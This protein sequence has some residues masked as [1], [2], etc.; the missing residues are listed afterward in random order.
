M[1][2]TPSRFPARATA[3]SGDDDKVVTGV[4][5]VGEKSLQFQSPDLA[6]EM[7][8]EE[9]ELDV[10]HAKNSP[11][12][13]SHPD[14][15]AWQFTA[16]DQRILKETAFTRRPN[17]LRQIKEGRRRDEGIG[18]VV[19]VMFFV[20][21][22]LGIP[23]VLGYQIEQSVPAIAGRVP[24]ELDQ[25]LGQQ[26]A[27]KILEKYPTD[28]KNPKSLEQLNMLLDRI[29][30]AE[31]RKI[32]TF[33]IHLIDD[34]H[35]NSFSVPSGDIFIF[36]GVLQ[37]SET[38]DTV[39]AVLATEIAFIMTRGGIQSL[40]GSKSSGMFMQHLL[41]NRAAIAAMLRSSSDDLIS[42][43][44]PNSI[45]S[46]VDQKAIQLLVEAKISPF[47]T[48]T[49]FR[50]LTGIESRLE[51]EELTLPLTLRPQSKA[52]GRTLSEA[53]QLIPSDVKFDELP[54]VIGPP[55]PVRA[56][57]EDSLDF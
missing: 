25:E 24:L 28:T 2:T 54:P 45:M 13:F 8:Y 53:Y 29:V 49:F 11:V 52:R 34:P 31:A 35:P 40:I 12:S 15:T 16:Y 1:A 21:A 47:G 57:S 9:L 19:A 33:K 56:D 23:F 55:L 38:L 46:I 50:T 6:L 36:T 20:F 26:L 3:T 7:P 4:L 51:Y 37:R 14:Q 17:L 43:G 39:A 42:R 30:P 48:A 32:H 41:N 5:V 27:T 10:S 22:F 18:Q 44:P